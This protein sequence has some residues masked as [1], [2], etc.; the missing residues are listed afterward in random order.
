MLDVDKVAEKITDNTRAIIPVDIAG[1]PFDYDA[2]KKVLKDN[3]LVLESNLYQ[4][5]FYPIVFKY[6]Y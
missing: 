3:L 6:Y 1:V 2:L 5:N 4:I